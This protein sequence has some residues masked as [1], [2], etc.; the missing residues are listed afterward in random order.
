[1]SR[2]ILAIDPGT[3]ESG[4]AILK[5][6]EIVASGKLPNDAMMERVR[7]SYLTIDDLVI[8]RVASYG[9]SVGQEVFDTCVWIGRFQQGWLYPD[10]VH[11]IFRKDVKIHVCNN[12]NAKDK[13]VR[14]AMLDMFGAPGTKKNPG[15][16]YGITGD[17]WQALALAVTFRDRW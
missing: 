8:E 6:T 14:Q 12:G 3:T 11:L 15:A 16:T 17:A 7:Y 1:V 10:R 4:F 2:T 13:N 9:M 5:G